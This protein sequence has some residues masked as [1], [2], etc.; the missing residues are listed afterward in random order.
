[1]KKDDKL[2][3]VKLP[4]EIFKT[5]KIEAIKD[6][7]SFQKLV[8]RS[9]FLYLKDDEFRTRLLNTVNTAFTGSI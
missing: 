6:K 4:H 9:M 5:F 7:F 3:S 1:M 2:T 8:E